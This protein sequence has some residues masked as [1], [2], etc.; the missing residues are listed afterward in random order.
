MVFGNPAALWLLALVPLPL[1]LS[2]RRP[3]LRQIVSHIRLWR[4]AARRTGT[5]VAPRRQSV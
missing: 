4:E 3:P 1:L 5:H 2:R